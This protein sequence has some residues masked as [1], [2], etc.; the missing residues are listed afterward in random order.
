MMTDEEEAL[1]A[2][3]APEIGGCGG[4][5][6][7]HPGKRGHRLLLLGV[8]CLLGFGNYYCYDQ[9]A[10]LESEIM[11]VSGVNTAQFELLYS[12]YSYPNVVLSVFG[13][14]L[15]D[16]V[17]GLRWGAVLFA[18]IITVGHAIF[19]F[20]AQIN[21]FLT[22]EI[23]RF[24]FGLGGENLAVVQN[25]Y[26]VSWFKDKELNMAF[27]LQLS[28]ARLGSTVN[29]LSS[30][31]AYFAGLEMGFTRPQSIGFSLW[32]GA[33]FCAMSLGAAFLL[34]HYDKRRTRLLEL[35]EHGSGEQ[36]R[37]RDVK[38][39]PLSLWLIFFICVAYYVSIFP[40]ISLGT[41]FFQDKYDISSGEAHL[42]D[43]L[44]YLIS[45]GGAFVF[46]I[47]VDKVGR[48]LL[49]VNIAIVFTIVSH[50]L[51]AFTFV[52][53][54]AGQILMGT[55]YSLLAC[56]LWPMVAMVMKEHQLGTAYGIMQAIQNLGLAVVAY[57][58]GVLVDKS[59]YLLLECFFLAWLCLAL[60]CGMIL[61]VVDSARGGNLNLSVAERDARKLAAEQ[62]A[63]ISIDGI[64]PVLSDQ[65]LSRPVDL[66]SSQDSNSSSV[67]GST[68]DVR[69]RLLNRVG[70]QADAPVHG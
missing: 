36:V 37:V 55:A 11:D 13:G 18:S 3:D 48:N 24:V 28:I 62:K 8:M 42:V 30:E 22:M 61:Y 60:F 67:S 26:A 45:L 35:P 46:G 19:A 64:A 32:I 29:M 1:L 54:Y 12:L 33:A 2:S 69:N 4:S 20:G 51:L 6:L 53:P 15:I 66:M 38:D 47:V 57:A 31:R 14:F 52:T 5:A 68:D 23:G 43:S 44:V 58:A 21:S 17:T 56:A 70:L 41:V 63:T 10:A 40:F 9:P 16:R 39:F 65:K 34:W 49:F 27:G 50:G 7:C 25:A 59:G